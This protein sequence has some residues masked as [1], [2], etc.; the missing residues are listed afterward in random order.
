MDVVQFDASWRSRLPSR[1]TQLTG[2]D[3]IE[4]FYF[5]VTVNYVT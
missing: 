4:F 5:T 1:E 3:V 2:F